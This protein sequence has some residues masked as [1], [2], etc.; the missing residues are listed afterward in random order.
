MKPSIHIDKVI[1]R[2]SREEV[3][4]HRLRLKTTINIVR[5]LAL[6]GCAF[7]GRDESE[8][9]LNH[10]NV[11][12]VV[13]NNAPKNAK[14]V[15]PSIRKEILSIMANQVRRKIHDEIGD[16]YFCILVDEAQDEAG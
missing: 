8:T 15:T 6:Q 3:I 5:K 9:S 2:V 12:K 16:A 4:K 1:E 13:L 7:R 10:E 11:K 14:Y